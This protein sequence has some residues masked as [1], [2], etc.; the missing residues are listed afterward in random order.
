MNLV[1]TYEIINC[2]EFDNTEQTFFICQ[3]IKSL[4]YLKKSNC[5]LPSLY[6]GY[7]EKCELEY[8]LVIS[9]YKGLFYIVFS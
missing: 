6:Y 8:K 9:M 5:S 4:T 2:I 7:V 1:Q 3:D